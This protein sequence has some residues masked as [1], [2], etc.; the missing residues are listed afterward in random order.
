[1]TVGPG[2]VVDPATTPGVAVALTT[3]VGIVTAPMT[4]AAVAVALTTGP[5]MVTVPA[6]TTAATV[7]FPL[8]LTSGPG[9]WQHGDHGQLDGHSDRRG[10][11]RDGADHYAW[12]SRD[13][14]DRPGS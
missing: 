4:T 8:A 6:T 3:G 13:R 9:S 14:V 1:M 11:D 5:G 12:G 2:I 10:R 7:A